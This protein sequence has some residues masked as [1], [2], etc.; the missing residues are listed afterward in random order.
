MPTI[1]LA[2]LCA[3]ESGHGVETATKLNLLPRIARRHPVA[4]L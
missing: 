3:R 2:L 1:A 4:G